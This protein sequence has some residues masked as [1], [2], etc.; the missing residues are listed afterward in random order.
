MTVN[1]TVIQ[2]ERRVAATASAGSIKLPS[3]APSTVPATQGTGGAGQRSRLSQQ[4]A[5]GRGRRATA[6]VGPDADEDAEGEDDIEDANMDE[7]GDA[8]DKSI[9]CFC[10]ERSY[11]EMIACDNPQCPY[12]W[13][14]GL[15]AHVPIYVA[16]CCDE[17]PFTLRQFEVT[18]ARPVVLLRMHAA[19]GQRCYCSTRKA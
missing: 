4:V 14:S 8:E 9:Y 12:Q 17:V 2:P 15:S 3:P 7:N 5:T 13:V 1:V 19:T 10:Q 18:S 16:D 6:S 11:G